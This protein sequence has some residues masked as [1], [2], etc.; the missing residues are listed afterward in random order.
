M[1][2]LGVLASAVLNYRALGGMYQ[3][4]MG[5]QQINAMFEMLVGAPS[6]AAMAE[7]NTSLDAAIG[8]GQNPDTVPVARVASA[9]SGTVE[10]FDTDE[11]DYVFLTARKEAAPLNSRGQPARVATPSGGELRRHKMARTFNVLELQVEQ[12]MNLRDPE[13]HVQDT[14]WRELNRQLNDQAQLDITTQQLWLKQLF[15]GPGAIYVDANGKILESSSGAAQTIATGLPATHRT[16][17]NLGSGAII[18][19]SW[20]AAGTKIASQLYRIRDAAQ[21]EKAERPKWVFLN[22]INRELFLNNTQIQAN[23]SGIDRLDEALNQ[24]VWRYQ[25]WNFVFTDATYEAADGS[26]Q[27]YIPVDKAAITPDLDGRWF[28]NAVGLEWVPDSA[29]RG[30]DPIQLLNALRRVYGM[31]SYSKIVDNPVRLQVFLG[32][33][34]YYGFKNPKSVW[35]PTI[36]F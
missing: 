11:V 25:D 14:G 29:F 21:R 9:G 1:A 7:L 35:V 31:F 12:F 24:P 5:K 23:Y 3:E 19:A 26:T 8:N 22:A 36:V 4:N 16:D 34:F 2:D 15:F 18:S 13:R 20:A 30:S 17:I 33:N 28:L 10:R 27:P 6:T 32:N